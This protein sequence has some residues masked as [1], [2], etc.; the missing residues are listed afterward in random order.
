MSKCL[1]VVF[2]GKIIIKNLE[3]EGYCVYLYLDNSEYPISIAAELPDDEF[4]SYI[5]D[6]LRTR[7]LHRLKVFK[8]QKLYDP[9]GVNR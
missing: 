5:K 8:L 9:I 7:Q 6:E 2:I 4:L 1:G 3:P